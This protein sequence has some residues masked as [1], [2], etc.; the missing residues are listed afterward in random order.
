LG[1]VVWGATT[2]LLGYAAGASYAQV[3][4]SFG[5]DVALAVVG[6]IVIA[7]LVRLVR[8]RRHTEARPT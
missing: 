1:G 2:V 8:R 4:K 5:R 7:V 3:E 6:L